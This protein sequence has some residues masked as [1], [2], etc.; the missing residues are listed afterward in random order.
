M[1]LNFHRDVQRQRADEEAKVSEIRKQA[2]Q[3]RSV[4]REDKNSQ[5]T[6]KPSHR[7]DP[8]QI[9]TRLYTTVW[10]CDEPLNA[11]Q[12]TVGSPWFYNPKKDGKSI[13]IKLEIYDGSSRS[14]LIRNLSSTHKATYKP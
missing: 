6:H 10:L 9:E 14:F 4:S 3:V 8:A 11:L 12:F 7:L 13:A 2:D 5:S 1:R